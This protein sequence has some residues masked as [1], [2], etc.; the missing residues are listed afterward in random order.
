MMDVATAMLRHM[1]KGRRHLP[2]HHPAAITSAAHRSRTLH[3]SQSGWQTMELQRLSMK[4]SKEDRGMSFTQ[5]NK[6]QMSQQGKKQQS[7]SK[8][9]QFQ[10]FMEQL[11]YQ[12]QN[13]SSQQKIIRPHYIKQIS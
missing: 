3:T 5:M 13:K 1:K 7:N 11:V 2:L 6:M 9:W 8:I 10:A 12:V 4:V